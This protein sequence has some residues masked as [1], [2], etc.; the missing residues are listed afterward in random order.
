MRN[1]GFGPVTID[2]VAVSQDTGAAYN[3]YLK[4]LYEMNRGNLEANERAITYF[5]RAL[6]DDPDLARLMRVRGKEDES[7]AEYQR[8]A[9]QDPLDLQAQRSLAN[10]FASRGRFEDALNIFDPLR[11]DPRFKAFIRKMNFRGETS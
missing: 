11:E 8:V 4:G 7:F 9:E 6:E 5:R 10:A 3:D 1:R 2:A